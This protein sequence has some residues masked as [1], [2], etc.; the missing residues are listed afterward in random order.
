ME[1]VVV[2]AVVVVGGGGG[3]AS[4]VG[5]LVVMCSL[6]V[7]LKR[8]PRQI[9]PP[10][11]AFFSTL[12]SRRIQIPLKQQQQQQRDHKLLVPVVCLLL[13]LMLLLLLM[14]AL[15]SLSEQREIKWRD[16]QKVIL[17]L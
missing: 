9:I 7:R 12:S 13:V 5:S 11:F 8:Y 4:S 15:R 17:H 2:V 14:R 10:A 3:G 1:L 6:A 16:R